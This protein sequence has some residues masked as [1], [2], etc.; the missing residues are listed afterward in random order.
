MTQ[1][2]AVKDYDPM[3]MDDADLAPIFNAVAADVNPNELQA[4]VV[5]IEA[6]DGAPLAPVDL[7]RIANYP[8]SLAR[9]FSVV[10]SANLGIALGGLGQAHDV[11]TLTQ[12]LTQVRDDG[13]AHFRAQ[14]QPERTAHDRAHN[15]HVML[16]GAVYR[17][18]CDQLVLNLP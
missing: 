9:S 12:A 14:R 16:M 13:V 11:P 2:V 6:R 7:H 8:K 15:A 3:M 10:V 18:Y 1:L 4:Y 17:S 5:A